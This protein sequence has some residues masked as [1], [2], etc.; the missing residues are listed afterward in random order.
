MGLGVEDLGFVR[1]FGFRGLGQFKVKPPPPTLTLVG[2][3]R[4][5]LKALLPSA[6]AKLCNLLHT[7]P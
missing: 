5:W 7:K 2:Q 6:T 1:G 4:V 3:F